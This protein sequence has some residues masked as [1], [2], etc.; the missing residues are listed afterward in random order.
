M[1]RAGRLLPEFLWSKRNWPT[2]GIDA[3]CIPA[4][5]LQ[6]LRSVAIICNWPRYCHTV[7][8]PLGRAPL[9][10]LNGAFPGA[11]TY[12]VLSRIGNLVLPCK[13]RIVVYYSG[14]NDIS[15][16]ENAG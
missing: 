10:V 9:P 8:Y 5:P 7:R 12:D 2:R 1:S 13:P 3:V 11:V 6:P 14:G 16:G 15:G 4:S